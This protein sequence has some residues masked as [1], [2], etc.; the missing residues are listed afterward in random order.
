MATDFKVLKLKNDILTHIALGSRTIEA[1]IKNCPCLEKYRKFFGQEA[2]NDLKKEISFDKLRSLSQDYQRWRSS[3]DDCIKIN[4]RIVE[5]QRRCSMTK[6]LGVRG[7]AL[8][9][10]SSTV[11]LAGA[12]IDKDEFLTQKE[13]ADII[14]ALEG[15]LDNLVQLPVFVPASTI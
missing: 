2:I 12:R 10:I 13:A 8:I 1:E 4:K 9:S 5:V 11:V 15:A 3:I 14:E 7:E 6:E